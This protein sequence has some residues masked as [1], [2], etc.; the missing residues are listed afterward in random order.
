MLL[1]L[2]LLALAHCQ[3]LAYGSVKVAE[4]YIAMTFDDGPSF[5]LT[6]KLLDILKER[7]IKVTFFI[8]G[9]LATRYPD[10]V[11]RA[12]AEGH[13]IADHTWDHTLITKLTQAGLDHQ[14][15]DTANVLR[16]ITGK[17]P[18]VFRPPY[19]GT[20]PAL[21]KIIRA[22]Y[23]MKV[24]LWS[25]DPD[26][27][28]RPG[29]A[30]VAKR[31]IDGA[32]N[33][34]IMLAH[35]IQ[36]GTIEAAPQ[37]FDTLLKKGFKFVTVSQLLDLAKIEDEVGNE[38]PGS[39]GDSLNDGG[40]KGTGAGGNRAWRTP[41][42]PAAQPPRQDA[43][44]SSSNPA[45]APPTVACV[46]DIDSLKDVQSMLIAKGLLAGPADG[47][48]GP[49]SRAALQAWLTRNNLPGNPVCITAP[50]IQAMKLSQ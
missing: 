45:P 31:L 9:S 26:D 12:A 2:A 44:S 3:P 42:A 15:I 38:H 18:R 25:V 14:V 35:D 33:G 49:K 32:R 4:P 10:I 11:K 48:F 36:P 24:I 43:A 37:M 46:T 16:S 30:V 13:E 6:P 22:A 39:A 29:P 1:L 40:A 27:W 19:G 21:N 5:A 50:I 17:W 41:D 20:S 28:K 47:M 34:A 8:L 7:N 23:N